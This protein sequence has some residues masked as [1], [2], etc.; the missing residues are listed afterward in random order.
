MSKSAGVEVILPLTYTARKYG[1]IT[2]HK[3]RDK[4]IKAILG[5]K[6]SVSLKFEDA[7]QKNKNIDWKHRR[8]AITYTLTRALPKNIRRVRLSRQGETVSVY[9][10]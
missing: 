4:E 10:E 5:D 6:G 2:W 1:Y 8:V 3:K 7:L 9:F